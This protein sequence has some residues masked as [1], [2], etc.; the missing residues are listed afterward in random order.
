M[1]SWRSLLL[2]GLLRI[3]R[4]KRQWKSAAA[5]QDRVRELSKRPAS[6]CPS[7]LRRNVQVS[8]RKFAGWPVYHT[9]PS[10]NPEIGNHV[11]FLHGGGYINE[12][13]SGHWRFVGHLTRNAPARCVVP[14]FPLAPQGTATDVVPAVGNLLRELLESV[15]PANVSVVGN[16]AGAGMALAAAQWLRDSGTPQPNI[17]VLISPWLDALV[18]RKEQVA[19]APRDVMLDI[20]GLAEAGRLYAGKL[21]V[22]HP[23]VSP[24]SGD[25]HGL[26]PLTVFSG[27]HD[28]LYPDSV[29]LADKAKQAGVPI[30]LHV[31][32]GLPHSYAM[33]PTPEGHRARAIIARAVARRS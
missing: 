13:V 20:P 7:G 15:G 21:N 32:K 2:N 27:T 11:L 16:S 4:V 31:E 22:T 23:L 12:I 29:A 9:A 30:D 6:H 24:L 33:F 1:P 19:I 5:V 8:L 14:I 10:A 3:L 28:V 17:L 25:L 26:A 18:G